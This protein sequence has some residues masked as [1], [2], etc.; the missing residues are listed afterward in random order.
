MLLNEYTYWFWESN[1][2]MHDYC[3]Q[4]YS[5]GAGKLS[6]HPQSGNKPR[7]LYTLSNN[8]YDD[9]CCNKD[10]HYYH[11]VP[12]FRVLH[13]L[14]R[15]KISLCDKLFYNCTM[16]VTIGLIRLV[17]W[18]FLSLPDF[19]L[20]PCRKIRR[21]PGIIATSWAGNGGLGYIVQTESTLH[22]NWLHHF[23]PVT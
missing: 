22:T 12:I 19:I 7:C 9:I 4:T 18:K 13:Q 1:E 5:D 8:Q 14:Q 2:T 3:A 6:V 15:R 23:R 10:Q 16:A 21:R 20:Q 17:Y 11:Q